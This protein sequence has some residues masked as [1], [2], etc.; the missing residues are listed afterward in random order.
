M[1]RIA[2]FFERRNTTLVAELER[3]GH[4][5]FDAKNLDEAFTLNE[6]ENIDIT[7]IAPEA[8]ARGNPLT[9]SFRTLGLSAVTTPADVV[10]ELSV[11]FPDSKTT[12]Q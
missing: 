12:I 11:Q 10:I 1:A 7:I 2:Y 9:L 8:R 4:T 3:A 6:Q 5:V